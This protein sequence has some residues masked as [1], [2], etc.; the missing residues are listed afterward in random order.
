MVRPHKSDG[1]AGTHAE[2][3][4]SSH[5]GHRQTTEG[6]LPRK[7]K[8]TADNWQGK[9]REFDFHSGEST[10]TTYTLTN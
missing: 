3:W 7:L 9:Q 5:R 8:I 6:G 4:C 10:A 1:E 2:Q